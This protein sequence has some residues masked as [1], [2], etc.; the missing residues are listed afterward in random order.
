[1]K[2][3][4]SLFLSIIMILSL[5]SCAKKEKDT[6]VLYGMLAELG[7][8]EGLNDKDS[9]YRYFDDINSMIIALES[10]K[11]DQIIKLPLSVGKYVARENDDIMVL[12]GKDF[13]GN[14][15]LHMGVLKENSSLYNQLNHAINTL[16]ENG[17]LE[18]L[19]G[20]YIESFAE[21]GK[22][23]KAGSIPFT[24]GL[25]TIRVAVTGDMPPIDYVSADGNPAGF[26]VALLTEIS[27]ILNVNI[28]LVTVNSASR[29]LALTENRV[30]VV[31]CFNEGVLE[32]ADTKEKIEISD[33]PDSVSI[34]D[35]YFDEAAAFL[36]KK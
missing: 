32:N 35:S 22:E 1:M 21:S 4:I 15:Y 5:A 26:N 16:S 13:V 23:P 29:L 34:T 6:K 24:P 9:Q 2:K 33:V 36:I 10:N 25:E 20:E 27:K 28:E 19:K 3:Y 8:P 30:D 14:I 18:R 11:I 31:F 17:T 7:T 12:N